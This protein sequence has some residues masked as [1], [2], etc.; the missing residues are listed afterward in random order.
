METAQERIEE[1][2]EHSKDVALLLRTIGENRLELLVLDVQEDRDQLLRV[3][4][5]AL[6]VAVFGLLGGITLTF[7]IVYVMREESLATTLVYLS[8]LY[9]L[10]VLFLCW[11]II[12]LLRNWDILS[13]SIEQ[14]RKDSLFQ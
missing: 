9:G 13:D 12:R 6:A 14:L 7:L 2:V 10:I 4:F 1:L 8:A 3:I 11:R 5:L